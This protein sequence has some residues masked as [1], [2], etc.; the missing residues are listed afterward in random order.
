MINGER[1]VLGWIWDIEMRSE[2]QVVGMLARIAKEHPQKEGGMSTLFDFEDQ[3]EQPQTQALKDWSGNPMIRA[4]DRG[5]ED[6][7]CRDCAFLIRY[8]DRSKVYLKCE[9]RGITHG[10]LYQHR[11]KWEA[12]SKFERSKEV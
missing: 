2:E 10:N 6:K 7:K 3:P 1:Y 5:P 4:Y 9:K 8:K 12:C 11:A